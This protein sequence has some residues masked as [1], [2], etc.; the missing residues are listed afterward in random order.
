MVISISKWEKTFTP[1]KQLQNLK[2]F[3]LKGYS[4]EHVYFNKVRERLE[5]H[6]ETLAKSHSKWKLKCLMW[7]Y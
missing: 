6:R 1:E 2:H 5:Q 7:D 3:I 4:F